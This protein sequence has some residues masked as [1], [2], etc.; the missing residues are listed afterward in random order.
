MEE[1]NREPCA[2]GDVCR[3]VTTLWK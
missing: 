2:W 3:I 1:M